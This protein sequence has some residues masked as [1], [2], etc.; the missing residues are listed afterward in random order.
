MKLVLLAAAVLLSWSAPV[1]AQRDTFD[2]KEWPVEWG[3]RTRDPAIAPDGKVA[4]VI[5]MPCD[6]V[7]TCAFGGPGLRTL[8]ITTAR[9]GSSPGSRLAGSLYAVE[10]EVPGLPEYRFRIGR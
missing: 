2:L 1:A 3:G 4:G 7:T 9:G 10:M 6:N 5:E 8:Y